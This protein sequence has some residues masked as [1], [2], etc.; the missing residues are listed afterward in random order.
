MGGRRETDGV[1]VIC[2]PGRVRKHNI[3]RTKNV[4]V[5]LLRAD[6]CLSLLPNILV[7]STLASLQRAQTPCRTVKIDQNNK[8][9]KATAVYFIVGSLCALLTPPLPA[10]CSFRGESGVNYATNWHT[11]VFM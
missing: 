5:S 9:I 11:F 3:S 7:Y 10:D 2:S 6:K 1:A 8:Q 4:S